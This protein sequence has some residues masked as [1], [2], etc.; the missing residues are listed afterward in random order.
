LNGTVEVSPFTETE[1]GR[2]VDADEA[3]CARTIRTPDVPVAP[4]H[5]A[6][7]TSNRT[8][9]IGMKKTSLPKRSLPR[10]LGPDVTA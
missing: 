9:R 2:E 1:A 7:A 8:I 10:F 4:L 6:K 3:D 5:R